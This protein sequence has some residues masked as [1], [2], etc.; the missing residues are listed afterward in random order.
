MYIYVHTIVGLPLSELAII[1]ASSE[2]PSDYNDHD[3]TNR[4]SNENDPNIYAFQS[5]CKTTLI[6]MINI[7]L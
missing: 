4:T 3:Y 6:T 5:C 2:V 1:S 7:Q